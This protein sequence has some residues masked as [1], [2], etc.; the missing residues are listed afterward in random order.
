MTITGK[1]RVYALLGD[2]LA[3][4]RT[5]EYFNGLFA[6]RGIDAMMVPLE[7][8]AAALQPVFDGL[9]TAR[10]L[11]GLIVTMPHK[12]G[13]C[14]LVDELLPNGRN[15]GAINAARRTPDG[16]WLGDM[17]DGRGYTGAL[18]KRGI[19]PKGK[20]VHMIGAGGVARAMAFALVDRG[21]AGLSVTDV[22]KAQAE[23]FLKDLQKRA[24]FK[25]EIT[26]DAADADIVINATPLGMKEGD[27][28]PYDVAKV[29]KGALVSDVTTKP[30]ITPFLAAAQ[31][32]GHAV[33]T[34]KDMFDAQV[35]LLARFFGWL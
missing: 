6:A 15:V 20:R 7:V 5:P 26:D 16:R 32:R 31:A 23:T 21:I 11:D 8:P 14:A 12:V 4:A 35:E 33:T 17:F 29:K 13:I 28:H 19:D 2:P 24:G 30:E 25:S 18:E 22:N 27:P 1:T 3:K 9:R 10:N 34:G